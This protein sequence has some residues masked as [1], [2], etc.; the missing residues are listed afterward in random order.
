MEHRPTV[1]ILRVVSRP[2]SESPSLYDYHWD[3]YCKRP[4][5]PSTSLRTTLLQD[6]LS[7]ATNGSRAVQSIKGSSSG[8]QRN[9]VLQY[10]AYTTTNG[11]TTIGDLRVQATTLVNGPIHP[12]VLFLQ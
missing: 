10:P 4:P 7:T 12:G 2:L 8:L 6:P 5:G 9:H 1:S 3:L 11:S